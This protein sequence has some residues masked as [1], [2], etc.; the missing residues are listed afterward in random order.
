ME[1]VYKLKESSK[2]NIY[3]REIKTKQDLIDL[4]N[5]QPANSIK[6]LDI[7]TH[8]GENSLYMVS[9]RQGDSSSRMN[10][11][12]WWRYFFNNETFKTQDLDS[13]QSE[14][15][16]VNV[17]IEIH[18]C[19]TA[20]NPKNGNNLASKWSKKLYSLGKTKS[21]V[22]GHTTNTSPLI[23]GASTKPNDQSYM[24]LERAIYKNGQLITLTKSK[25]LL[26]EDALTK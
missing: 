6:S 18:G 14:V 24:W 22:I 11:Y 20:E 15:F 10:K 1:R 3:I 21:V 4:I 19:K 26:D 8:G 7:F 23:N 9:V 17:K 13:F 25:G 2:Y 12:W 5:R 16:T